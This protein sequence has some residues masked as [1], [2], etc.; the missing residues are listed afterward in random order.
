MENSIKKFIV[1]KKNENKY[2]TFSYL[3]SEIN[4]NRNTL[5]KFFKSKK[6]SLEIADKLFKFYNAEIIVK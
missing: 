1:E 2:H 6:G 3:S 4:V 5:I